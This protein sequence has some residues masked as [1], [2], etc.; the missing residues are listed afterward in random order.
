MDKKDAPEAQIPTD[1]RLSITPNLL[2]D[3]EEQH[4]Q[5]HD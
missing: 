1:E 4:F 3:P 2:L 5:H